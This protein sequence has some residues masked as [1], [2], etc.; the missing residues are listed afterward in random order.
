MDQIEARKQVHTANAVAPCPPC[1][2]PYKYPLERRNDALLQTL[3]SIEVEE[4][5]GGVE[6]PWFLMAS[7]SR[8]ASPAST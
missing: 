3:A 7:A 6:I 5:Q 1:A 4:G 2:A 8:S